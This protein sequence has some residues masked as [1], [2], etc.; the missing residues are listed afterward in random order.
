MSDHL[1]PIPWLDVLLILAL[2]VLNGVLAMS[3]LAIV[4]SR[5]AR[6][7]AMAK[8]GSRGAQ[9]ALDLS[10]DPGRFLSTVQTGIT[11]ISIFAG[12]FS[13]ASLGEPVAQRVQ[14]LG[15]ST[16]T[17]HTIGFGIVIVA[18][19]YVSLVIGE[20]VPKTIALRSPEPIA[21]IM[22]RPLLWLSKVTAPFVWLLDR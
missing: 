10:S 4:S 3:E 19:T 14:Q 20:I 1:S 22:S 13:G 12:A 11:L 21:V 18:T 8:S 16:E 7:K 17:A 6:L 5:E 9:C 15:L 2:I